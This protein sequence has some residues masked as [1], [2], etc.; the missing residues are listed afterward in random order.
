MLKCCAEMRVVRAAGKKLS[1]VATSLWLRRPS[2]GG[3]GERARL[4][5]LTLLGGPYPHQRQAELQR[6]QAVSA[7]AST[8]SALG[9]AGFVI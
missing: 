9:W 5:L 2:S 6:L 7:S 1:C 3:C 8:Q 4:L